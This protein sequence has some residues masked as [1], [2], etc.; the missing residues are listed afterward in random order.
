MSSLVFYVTLVADFTIALFLFL[1]C[2]LIYK[3]T[4]GAS[5]AYF[6]WA[7]TATI[8]FISVIF[9][10]TMSIF[11]DID[12]TE[13]EGFAALIR[14]IQ[15]TLN[16]VA[17]YY[18]ALGAI[19]LTSNL[20][21]KDWNTEKILKHQ[22][23]VFLGIALWSLFII[24]LSMI[25]DSKLPIVQF[26]RP[27]FAIAWS[28]V[29]IAIIPLYNTVKEYAKYWSFFIIGSFFGI[30]SHITDIIVYFLNDFLYL[31][32]TFI[33]PSIIFIVLGFYKLGKDLEAF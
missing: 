20:K 31:T 30:I 13:L 14:V 25:S 9:R 7:I 3:R 26:Y 28:F 33:I 12:K 11:V 29:F 4:P 2:L 22:K 10:S 21:I 24:L 17:Y 5:K 19:V 8:V 32:I 18:M 15:Y 27:F 6:Y 16:S 23:F 1:F